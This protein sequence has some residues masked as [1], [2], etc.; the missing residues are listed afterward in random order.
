MV[1]GSGFIKTVEKLWGRE[2]WIANTPL[3]CL[4]LL[5]I[6]PGGCCSLHYHPKK[7]ETFYV[8]EGSCHVQIGEETRELVPGDSVRIPPGTPHR[9]WVPKGQAKGCEIMEVSTH[10]DDS[11]V[12]RLEESTLL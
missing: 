8:N 10:H 9:F 1:I 6:N 2:Y 3:Y 11:D 7:D 4:K 5:Q 12:I